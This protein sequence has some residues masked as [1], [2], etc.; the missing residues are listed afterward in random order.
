MFGID[1]NVMEQMVNMAQ[2]EKERKESEGS[3]L[4]EVMKSID[5][6]LKEVAYAASVYSRRNE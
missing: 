4:L 3:E 6:S 2:A 1:N 5:K